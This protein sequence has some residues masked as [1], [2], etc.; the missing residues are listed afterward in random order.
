MVGISPD[1]LQVM[2]EDCIMAI[3]KGTKSN[4]V[5]TYIYSPKSIFE[6]NDVDLVAQDGEAVSYINQKIR[7]VSVQDKRSQINGRICRKH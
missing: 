5:P 2:V 6:A 3:K 7:K 4:P 1:K